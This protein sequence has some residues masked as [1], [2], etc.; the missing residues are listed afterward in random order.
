M[1]I[2][3]W[4]CPDKCQRDLG[5]RNA[6]ASVTSTAKQCDEGNIVKTRLTERHLNQTYQSQDEANIMSF[7]KVIF[8]GGLLWI[9]EPLY[10][11]YFLCFLMVLDFQTTEQ[12][13]RKADTMLLQEAGVTTRA[14]QTNTAHI[15]SESICQNVYERKRPHHLHSTNKK[16]LI[17]MI[18]HLLGV[19][20]ILLFPL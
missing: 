13:I 14:Q 12:L 18:R 2:Y 19:L 1:R 8:N 16:A 5:S 3:S 9:K 20:L 15:I 10:I 7:T 11:L 6:S 17:T 4:F